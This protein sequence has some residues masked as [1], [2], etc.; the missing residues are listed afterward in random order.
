MVILIDCAGYGVPLWVWTGLR[1]DEP[2]VLEVGRARARRE[3]GAFSYR[4]AHIAEFEGRTAG[5]LVGYRLADPYLMPDLDSVPKEFE[6]A[7]ELES[8][9][10]GSWFVNV[11]AV[12]QEYR[13][14]GIGARLLAHA[15]ELARKAHATRMS[16]IFESRN[17]GARRVYERFG[18]REVSRRRRITFPSDHTQSEEWVLMSKSVH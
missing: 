15:E 10:P 14:Q 5:M 7:F 1:K 16:I 4:N 11:V 12:Y 9:V 17:T 18:F 6:P 8:L 13:G 3:E 2:S